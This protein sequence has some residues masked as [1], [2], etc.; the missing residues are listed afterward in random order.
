MYFRFSFDIVQDVDATT[1]YIMRYFI[2][3]MD[4][5]KQSIH[6]VHLTSFLNTYIFYIKTKRKKLNFVVPL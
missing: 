5:L 3:S 4:I 2:Y 6:F 1:L